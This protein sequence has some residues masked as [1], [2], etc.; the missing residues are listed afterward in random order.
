MNIFISGYSFPILENSQ[1]KGRRYLK[2]NQNL[3]F[4]FNLQ[5]F[6]MSR[7]EKE[8]EEEK[9]N[10][11]KKSLREQPERLYTTDLVQ[12]LKFQW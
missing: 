2:C 12:I 10:E 8:E 1:S 4:V 5:K 3:I 9:E 7:S 11:T 6:S